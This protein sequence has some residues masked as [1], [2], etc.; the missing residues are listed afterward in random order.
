MNAHI[1]RV[2]AHARDCDNYPARSRD[3]DAWCK[4]LNRRDS[5]AAPIPSVLVFTVA[6]GC[7]RVAVAAAAVR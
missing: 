7:T 5:M 1:A 3:Q 4:Q 6:I 2:H